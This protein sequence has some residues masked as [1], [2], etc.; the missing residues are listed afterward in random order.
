MLFYPL[1]GGS[2]QQAAAL[3]PPVGVEVEARVDGQAGAVGPVGGDDIDI[4]VA[5]LGP[6]LHH[7]PEPVGGI[8]RLARRDGA[9]AD[10]VL[11]I[12]PAG[13]GVLHRHQ[14]R[15]VAA[16]LE[17][18]EEDKTAVGGPVGQVVD[19]LRAVRELALVRPVGVHHPDLRA[20]LVQ[21][22][23]GDLRPVRRPGGLLVAREALGDQLGFACCQVE[24]VD[25][26]PPALSQRGEGDLRPIRRPGRVEIAAGG[27]GQRQRVFLG[28]GDVDDKQ[29]GALVE[30]LIARAGGDKDQV[31]AVGGP[32][33]LAGAIGHVG[34]LDGHAVRI[35]GVLAVHAD[36]VDLVGAVPVGG[37]SHPARPTAA[38]RGRRGGGPGLAG[39]GVEGGG[40]RQVEGE[41]GG[42]LRRG[43]GGRG[44]GQLGGVLRGPGGRGLLR[45]GGGEG[46]RGAG[47]GQEAGQRLGGERGVPDE[48]KGR[49]SQAE[50]GEDRQVE[51]PTGPAR[52]PAA[53]V[54]RVSLRPAE[55]QGERGGLGEDR[56]ARACAERAADAAAHQVA[57]LE[58]LRGRL[59]DV[60]PGLLPRDVAGAEQGHLQLF[61]RLVAGVGP[62][63]Q[64]AL[65]HPRQAFRD[66][67]VAL[68]DG[69]QLGL[70]HGPGQGILGD[71]PGEGSV[72]RGPERE[73]VRAV[74]GAG[75]AVLLRRGIAGGHGAGAGGGHLAALHDLRQAEIHQVDV[76]VGGDLHVPRLDIPVHD[77]LCTRVEISERVADG[78]AD[79]DGLFLGDDADPVHAL[80]QV[81]AFDVVHH[82]VLA[83]V[84]DDEV[85]GHARQVGVAQAGEDDGLAA[86][87]PGVLLGGE[88]VLFDRHLH[89]QV[90]VDG[91]INRSHATLAQDLLNPIAVI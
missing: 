68:A 22:D 51:H 61:G 27:F 63:L 9:D 90:L 76:A 40:G 3:R 5:A 29:P 23:I 55:G 14:A 1:S 46:R 50:Q 56:R 37:E 57:V 89:A 45:G 19:H 53:Q 7:Q 11:V 73:E 84:I 82:Q 64:G 49:R 21:R 43:E 28:V 58:A 78:R 36:H 87:L 79:D 39:D 17:L 83:L 77:G 42:Q 41:G 25:A 10:D 30:V 59:H 26:R 12:L 38:G 69:G 2:G 66:L 44:G 54:S 70:F 75:G 62:D 48:D 65:Q 4:V 80:A 33:R 85:V 91:A 34:E 24:H 60:L 52:A 67:R 72:E 8:A 15:D 18:G 16:L 6:A 81:L 20:A 32:V 13:A 86:E 35:F 71:G 47:L 31:D 74:I 88:Q